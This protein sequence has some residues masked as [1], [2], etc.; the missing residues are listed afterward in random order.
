MKSKFLDL[1]IGYN[2]WFQTMKASVDI[3]ILN[4]QIWGNPDINIKL[5]NRLFKHTIRY[6]SDLN[7]KLERIHWNA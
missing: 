7:Q 4:I 1:A 3:N 2:R 6:V 5:N